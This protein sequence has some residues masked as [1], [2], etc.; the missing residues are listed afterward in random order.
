MRTTLNLL[1]ICLAL[2][3]ANCTSQSNLSSEPEPQLETVFCDKAKSYKDIH[4]LSEYV[5]SI[6]KTSDYVGTEVNYYTFEGQGLIEVTI[7]VTS[8]WI[9]DLFTCDGKK[10]TFKTDQE[11]QNFLKNRNNKVLVWSF[12]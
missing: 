4:W 11:V 9:D 6:K 8:V 3:L 10:I 5:A 12:N 2:L 7:P 1:W